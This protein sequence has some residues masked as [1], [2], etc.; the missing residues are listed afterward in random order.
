MTF[1]SDDNPG[2]KSE[3][4]I[5]AYNSELDRLLPEIYAKLRRIAAHHLKNERPN[6]TLSPTDLV[7]EAFLILRR[8]H[9]LDLDDRK[10]VLAIASSL[11]RRVL[12]NYAKFRR[13]K[14]R[15]DGKD[16]IHLDEVGE[17]TFVTFERSTI[18]VI[19]LENAL[20]R[21]EKR[22]P[23]QVKIVEMHFFGGL[24]FD[25]IAE[26]LGISLRT[27]MREWK[28]A[29]TWLYKEIAK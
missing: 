3:S 21:L 15:G 23:R 29:R 14:K 16:A 4:G 1:D 10:Y 19:V 27:V 28:F 17:L 11:M 9:S 8:Q 13:R 20:E 2:G 18:D 26:L 5:D 7:H 25:E 22:D 6:H 24:T 12:V